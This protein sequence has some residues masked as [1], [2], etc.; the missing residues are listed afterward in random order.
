MRFLALALAACATP[1]Y[2]DAFR[3]RE[4]VYQ[5]LGA[6][7]AATTCH[8]VNSG[9]AIEGNPLVSAVIGKRPSCG[10][11]IAFKAATGVLHWLI[12]REINKRD[13]NGA[14]VFQVV[15]IG[16]QGGVVVANLRF[17]F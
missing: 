16:V 6:A 7:D 13:P 2:A 1:A 11:V 12:A 14:K 9:Q 3:D 5:V 15:S 8:A 4:I 10:G 17:V